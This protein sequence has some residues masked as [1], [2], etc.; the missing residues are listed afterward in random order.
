MLKEGLGLN[1]HSIRNYLDSEERFTAVLEKLKEMG[2]T[3][4]EGYVWY[5]SLGDVVSVDMSVDAP[6]KR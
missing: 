4:I 6:S 5:V 3:Y 2:Y 1:L